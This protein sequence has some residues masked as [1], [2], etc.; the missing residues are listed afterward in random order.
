M[1]RLAAYVLAAL[2]F[3][4]YGAMTNVDRDDSGAIVDA[5]TLDAFQVQ[6]GDCF[7]DPDAYADE[8]SRL[9]PSSI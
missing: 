9:M 8:F 5:G 7:D 3:G 6:L 2:G 1:N 4:I